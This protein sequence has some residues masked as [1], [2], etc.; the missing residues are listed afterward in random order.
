MY[1]ESELAKFLPSD[2][3]LLL[4]EVVAIFPTLEE[5]RVF[6]L[7]FSILCE[8]VNHVFNIQKDHARKIMLT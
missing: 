7:Y 5:G 8:Y 4:Q 3:S 2:T 6:R 1:D